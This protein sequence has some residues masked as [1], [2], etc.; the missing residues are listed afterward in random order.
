MSL[1]NVKK[2]KNRG[3]MT[4]GGGEQTLRAAEGGREKSSLGCALSPP[5]IDLISVLHAVLIDDDQLFA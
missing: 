1:K 5:G 2:S 3:W 4:E